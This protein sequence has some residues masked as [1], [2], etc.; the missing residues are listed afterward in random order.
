MPK[1]EGSP[2]IAL[3]LPILQEELASE[4]EEGGSFAGQH[5]LRCR[6]KFSRQKRTKIQLVKKICTDREAERWA[7][8]AWTGFEGELRCLGPMRYSHDTCSAVRQQ[9]FSSLKER[10]PLCSACSIRP[11]EEQR[12]YYFATIPSARRQGLAARFM[13]S[14]RNCASRYSGE[15]V[16]LATEMGAKMYKSYGFRELME[17]PM[18]FSFG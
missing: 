1:E 13:D 12:L 6:S 8:A 15:M 11:G 2:F 7:E 16:L 9:I 4:L 10:H 14:L 3:Q 5:I 18:L 17:V